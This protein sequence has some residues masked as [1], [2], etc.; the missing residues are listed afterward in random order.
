MF[1]QILLGALVAGI[2]AGRGYTDWPFM[3]GGFF[4]PGMWDYTPWWRNFFE[5]DG[6]VQFVHRLMGYLV[7]ILAITAWV[8]ARRSPHP[9]TRSAFGVMAAMVLLQIALGVV[10]VMH[11]SPLHIAIFHQAGAILTFLLILRARYHARYP[12]LRSL[13][14]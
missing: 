1:L 14:G 3:A 11:S 8:R 13:R 12:A 2:D 7:L 6:T 10:T 9:S 5:N 4:P